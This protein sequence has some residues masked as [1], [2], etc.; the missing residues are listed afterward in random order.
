MGRK[1]PQAVSLLTAIPA[2]ANF[3]RRLPPRLASV[4]FVW[5]SEFT[6]VPSAVRGEGDVV[7][8]RHLEVSRGACPRASPDCFSYRFSLTCFP[9]VL[10]GEGNSLDFTQPRACR[11]ALG[12]A[13]LPRAFRVG[14]GS[15]VSPL[16]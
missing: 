7:D 6:F 12:P 16:V 10:R 5:V 2:I 14:F 9:S 11:A 3:A 13:P 8:F 4:L 1:L 15:P